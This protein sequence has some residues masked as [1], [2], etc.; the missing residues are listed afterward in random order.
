[1]F[2]QHYMGP[3]FPLDNAWAGSFLDQVVDVDEKLAIR[4]ESVA[5]HQV[6]LMRKGLGNQ[7]CNCEDL[8]CAACYESPTGVV[9]NGEKSWEVSGLM[10]NRNNSQAEA[11]GK[12]VRQLSRLWRY[13]DGGH[14]VD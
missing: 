2:N 13:V 1:M 6:K 10:L 11:R 4:R 12:T 5:V 9:V 14:P 8:H 3:M 7:K